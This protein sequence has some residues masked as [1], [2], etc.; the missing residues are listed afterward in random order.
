[1]TDNTHQ[2]GRNR[3]RINYRG[4]FVDGTVFYDNKNGNPI[5]VVVGS[6][7]L[8]GARD[9]ALAE[10]KVGEEQTL[11]IPKAYGEYHPDAVQAKVP[12]YKIPNGDQLEE[13]MELMWT[14]PANPLNPVPTKVLRADKFTVDLDFNHPLAGKDLVYW[15][16]LVELLD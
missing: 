11:T 7:S 15:V 3:V 14:S 4:S 5:E 13:G 1:M 12:R 9:K 2:T 16:K 8:P 6:R 10:M